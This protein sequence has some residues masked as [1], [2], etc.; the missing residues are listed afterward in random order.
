MGGTGKTASLF[1][2]NGRAVRLVGWDCNAFDRRY[3]SRR[4]KVRFGR[5]ALDRRRDVVLLPTGDQPEFCHGEMMVVAVAS[6]IPQGWID[7][8]VVGC[9]MV[10]RRRRRLASR[11]CP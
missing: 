2:G 11:P 9:V 4:W 8:M 5:K 10:R 6:T 1:E 7:G 3:T